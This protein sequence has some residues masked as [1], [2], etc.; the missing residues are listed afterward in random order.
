MTTDFIID[1]NIILS[2]LISGKASYKPLLSYYNFIAP[3]FALVEI[4]KYSKIIEEKSKLSKEDLNKYSLFVFSQ[5]TLLPK[6]LLTSES[7]A[8]AEDLVQN[9]DIKDTIYIALS[10]ELGLTLITRDEKLYV[11]LRKKG[12]KNIILFDDFYRNI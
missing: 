6:F 3:D 7:L 8:K 5:I 9:I 10:I 1:A 12:Y 11:G 2:I 4:D